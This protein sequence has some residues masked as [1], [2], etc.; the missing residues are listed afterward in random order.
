[1][2]ALEG[3]GLAERVRSETDRR[4]VMVRATARGRQVLERGRAARVKLVAGLIEGLSD[5]DRQSLDRAASIIIR[6]L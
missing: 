4:V 1:V 3:A 5:K 2:S 6:L